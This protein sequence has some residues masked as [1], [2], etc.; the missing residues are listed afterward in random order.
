M[1]IFLGGTAGNST[2]RKEIAIPLLEAAGVTY[3][4]PQLG[5][6]E[7]TPSHQ[8]LEAKEKEEAAVWLFVIL[9]ETRGVASLVEAAFRI[10]EG[11]QI[12]LAVMDIDAE[13]LFEGQALGEQER[14]DM[15]RGRAYL[16]EVATQKG[17]PV[18]EDIAAATKYAISLVSE[19]Q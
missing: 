17:V 6:G 4:N 7:W 18:F 9:G 5:V 19:N 10:G 3:F 16:R 11:G 12:A 8:Q 14:K 2:W 15:N 1:Q 13:I